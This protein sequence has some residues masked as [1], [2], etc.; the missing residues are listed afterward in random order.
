MCLTVCVPLTSP[1]AS[2]GD[3]QTRANVASASGRDSRR[4]DAST[5]VLQVRA[6]R[7]IRGRTRGRRH[8]P[9]TAASA[10]HASVLDERFLEGGLRL[11]LEMTVHERVALPACT[12][13]VLAP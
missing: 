8:A 13:V 2:E 3:A 5:C 1:A 11:R 12:I 10:P 7:Q 6:R 4:G 9:T